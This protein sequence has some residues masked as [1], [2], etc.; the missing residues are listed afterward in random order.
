[1]LLLAP[2]ATS[3]GKGKTDRALN[4]DRH[5]VTRLSRVGRRGSLALWGEFRR[6]S[7]F[8]A[9]HRAHVWSMVGAIVE[10]W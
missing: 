3:L 9:Y 1:M 10:L 8:F 5:E 4:E 6:G 2:A 7:T